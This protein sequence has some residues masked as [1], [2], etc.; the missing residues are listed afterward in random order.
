[1]SQIAINTSQNV[2]INFNI[3]SIGERFLAF[4]I[5]NVI[6]AVYAFLILYLFFG[7]FNLGYVLDG[8]DYWSEGAV[9]S[10]LLFPTVIYPLVL[11]SLMEGQT[12]GKKVIK[13]RVVKID[14]YQAS[15]GDYLIRWVFRVIDVSFLVVGFIVMI[16]T[17]NNQ[18]FGDIAAGTAVISLKNNINISHTILENLQTD[19]IP[20]FPQVIG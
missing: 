14:G 13:I 9:Y 19:Y 10:V 3:A 11:E 2:N 4:I 15:F 16:V 18:R 20:T 17:K 5:D 8:L 6:M 7:V 1:M 12:L